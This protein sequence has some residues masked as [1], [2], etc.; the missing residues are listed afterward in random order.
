MK[1]CRLAPLLMMSCLAA[2]CAS[3]PTGNGLMPSNDVKGLPNFAKVSDGLYRGAQPT[4]EGFAELKKMGVKTVVNLR[5]MHSDRQML[6]GTGLQYVH[7]PS[8]AWHPED[9]DLVRFLKVVEDPANRP[10]FVHCQQGA[11]RTGAA[12]AVYRMVEENWAPADAAAELPNFGFHPVWTE[13]TA[14][15]KKFDAEGTRKKVEKAKMPN[16]DVVE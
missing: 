8:H 7:L 11:D 15:L 5:S 10:V 3:Q 14:Y 4:A 9:A 12:V 1:P 2:A 6:K 16:I 13:I